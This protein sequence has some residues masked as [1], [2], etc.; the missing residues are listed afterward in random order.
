VISRTSHNLSNQITGV[1]TEFSVRGVHCILRQASR[2]GNIVCCVSLIA[3]SSHKRSNS[4]IQ[5]IRQQSFSKVARRN[6][7]ALCGWLAQPCQLR[8]LILNR[9][10]TTSNFNRAVLQL[11]KVGSRGRRISSVSINPTLCRM[12]AGKERLLQE[13]AVKAFCGQSD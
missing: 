4:G 6:L 3:D 9:A 13:V 7:N 12:N 2:C 8:W 5:L 10:E 1:V 11:C